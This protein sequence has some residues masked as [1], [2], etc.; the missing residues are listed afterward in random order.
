M[1]CF[2]LV[3]IIRKQQISTSTSS[4]YK[5]TS[6]ETRSWC[7]IWTPYTSFNHTQWLS[8][9]LLQFHYILLE[10]TET[11]TVHHIAITDLESA[12]IM[13]SLFT[14]LPIHTTNRFLLN[15]SKV[16]FILFHY[17]VTCFC[18]ILPSF[19]VTSPLITMNN[20]FLLSPNCQVTIQQ[21]LCYFIKT[22]N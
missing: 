1:F 19:T 8:L 2:R 11:R 20:R 21:P 16:N 9:N 17:P 3:G 5:G 15:L 10:K 4:K 13:S 22:P 14:S 6:R 7:L 12:R 18:K